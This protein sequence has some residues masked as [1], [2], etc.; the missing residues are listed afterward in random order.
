MVLDDSKVDAVVIATRHDSHAELV[1]E[2]LRAGKHVFVEKP[3]CLSRDELDAIDATYRD[4]SD[5]ALLMVGFNRRFAPHVEQLHMLLNKVDEPKSFIITVNAGA[6]P[7]S[8][9]INNP[10]IGGG[11]ILGE[12]CHFIDLLR[13]LAGAEIQSYSRTSLKTRLH[14]T[15]SIQLSFADGSIGT[16][17]YFENG[18]RGFP[19]ERLEVF[20]RDKIIQIDNFRRAKAYGWGG[21]RGLNLWRQN[22][23]QIACAAAFVNAIEKNAECPIPYDQIYEVAKVSIDLGSMA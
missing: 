8:H 18:S 23:G 4:L 13:H 3:L 10:K 1:I 11:R 21:L 12:A 7:K 20:C 5:C 9:W 2:A 22:K 14:D 15:A 16:I 19:K 6:I 17:H